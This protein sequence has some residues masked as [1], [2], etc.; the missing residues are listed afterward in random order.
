MVHLRIQAPNREASVI[1]RRIAAEGLLHLVDLAH[2]KN[3]ADSSPASTQTLLPA[4][5][6]LAKR[7]ERLTQHLGLPI[8]EPEGSLSADE[9]LDLA[10]EREA[11]EAA[12]APIEESVLT[13]WRD[14]IAASER[15]TRMEEAGARLRRLE[16]A[17]VDLERVSRL[18]FFDLM[19]GTVRTEELPTLATL[20]APA[21]FAVVPLETE[22]TSSL[23]AVAVSASDRKRL[24]D[25]CRVVSLVPFAVA[26]SERDRQPSSL[27]KEARQAREEQARLASE[28]ET[29]KESVGPVLFEL[30]RRAQTGLLLLQAQTFFAAAGRFVVIS[31][32]VPEEGAERLRLALVAKSE[33]RVI[34]EIEKPEDLPE[35]SSGAL[36][37]PILHRNPL[38][39]RP[40][41]KLIGLYGTP[42]YEEVQPT[43]FFAVSFLLMFGLMFGDVGHGVV[44]FLAGYLLFRRIPR[45]L[46]Y[47][48]LLMEGGVAATLFGF[49]YGSLFGLED[50]LPT[51]W[52]SPLK[53]MQRFLVL[54]MGLGVALVSLGLLLNVVNT[55]RAGQ[56]SLALFGPRGL[57]PAFGYW[58]LAAL[59]ARA[60]VGGSA[61]LPLWAILLLFAV[62]VM[63]LLLKRPIVAR[64]EKGAPVRRP[65]SGPAPSWLAALEGSVELV[66]TMISYF[67]NTVSFLRV[68]AFAMVH[69]G[70]F[71]ALF[72]L[73]DTLSR[74]RAGAPLSILALVA[75]NVVM[76]FLEG[77]TVSVQVLRLE[78]YE[79]FGKFFRGGGEPY[80]PLMLRARA[81]KG[82]TS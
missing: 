9:S 70:A 74:M 28:I 46:D 80:R 72:A 53:D 51:L 47:G 50:V 6:D 33:G 49:L 10:R 41:D 81:V 1:T 17:K 36:R 48:I 24:D 4:Y 32:W 38:L 77:L 40:F 56:R 45:Y 11:L 30:S 34:V 76:I 20:L 67:A 2:G 75:G 65:A 37:V 19:F 35:V 59:A 60:V 21:P 71:L 57:L 64:L 22:D 44:L 79:F 73:A 58:V 31:G 52:M 27:E 29:E 39:L 7:V 69:A 26:E 3:P 82:A 43:A 25:A 78:Y 5:R 61:R 23:I 16:D 68:A 13:K 42:S 63:L 54:A 55:W 8:K 14:R 66:D 62:P 12:L 18:R 15:A